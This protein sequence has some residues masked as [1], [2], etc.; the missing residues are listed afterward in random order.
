MAEI[1][2]IK[3][4]EEEI[5][6]NNSEKTNAFTKTMEHNKQHG[7]NNVNDLY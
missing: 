5:V 1:Q 2:N 6:L 4:I 3:L 7:F